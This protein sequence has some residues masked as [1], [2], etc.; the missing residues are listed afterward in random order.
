MSEIMQTSVLWVSI[1]CSSSFNITPDGYLSIMQRYVFGV[2]YPR[3]VRYGL[4]FF[5]FLKSPAGH[6]GICIALNLYYNLQHAM[7]SVGYDFHQH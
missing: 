4:F 6:C 5:L 2:V 3:L 1:P 7:L